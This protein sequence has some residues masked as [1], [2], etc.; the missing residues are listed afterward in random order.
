[1]AGTGKKMGGKMMAKSI[2]D[3]LLRLQENLEE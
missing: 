1:M 3:D 2:R